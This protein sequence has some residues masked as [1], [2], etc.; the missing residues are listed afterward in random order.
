MNVRSLEW[1]IH[2]KFSMVSVREI[3]D[4]GELLTRERRRLNHDDRD[5]MRRFL[6]EQPP[7]TSVAM[8]A[9]FVWPWVADLV[10][11]CDLE[12]HLA[13]PPAVRVLAKHQAKSDRCD[14][15]Q[16]AEFYL[17]GLLPESYLAP[18]SVRSLRERARHR[19]AL[20]RL[21]QSVKNRVQAQ[22]HRLGILHPF[23][24]LFGKTGQQVF[25]SGLRPD[26]G[27]CRYG[28]GGCPWSGK[29]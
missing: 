25:R 20:S 18:P 8:A 14:A 13:H 27:I 9:A 7:S 4:D 17:M 10:E 23:S 5:V 11:E 22:L 2:R 3:G 19:M 24:P 15:D 1:D 26:A 16:L 28:S 21:R 6:A 29:T 12:P